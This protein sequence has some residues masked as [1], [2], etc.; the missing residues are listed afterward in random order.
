[1][2]MLYDDDGRQRITPGKYKLIAGGCSP[3]AR[4]VELGAPQP[5]AKLYSLTM[6]EM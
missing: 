2:L 6:L 5:V 1:M 4:G 3:G